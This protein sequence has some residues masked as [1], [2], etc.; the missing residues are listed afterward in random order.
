MSR[1]VPPTG[2][3]VGPAKRRYLTKAQKIARWEALG[4]CCTICGLPCEAFGRSVVWDHRLGVWFGE[5]TDPDRMDV[6]HA[7]GCAP[8]KTAKDATVRAKVKRLVKKAC[9][10]PRSP[11]VIHSRGFSPVSRGFNGKITVAK[12]PKPKPAPAAKV[13]K[14]KIQIGAVPP[15]FGS[16][17]KQVK[18]KGKGR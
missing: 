2:E 18:P 9:G 10:A 1:V 12:T 4:R 15:P 5:A 13:S 7:R 17:L 11:S 14:Y 3:P 6:H 16:L 8:A